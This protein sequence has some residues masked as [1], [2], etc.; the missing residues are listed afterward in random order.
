[1]SYLETSVEVNLGPENIFNQL[2]A[3]SD[4]V[5]HECTIFCQSSGYVEISVFFWSVFFWLVLSGWGSVEN[6]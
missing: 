1:M 5:A 4:G 3:M 6:R 2:I